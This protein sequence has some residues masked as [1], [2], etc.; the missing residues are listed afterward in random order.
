MS[1]HV[2]FYSSHPIVDGF[3]VRV[4]PSKDNYA[5]QDDVREVVSQA[6]TAFGVFHDEWDQVYLNETTKA[7]RT[8]YGQLTCTIHDEEFQ[9][10]IVTRVIRDCDCYQLE[11]EWCNSAEYT[12]T[13]SSKQGLV[14][15][16]HA[17]LKEQSR[18]RSIYFVMPDFDP[19][20]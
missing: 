4:D 18:K 8:R 20:F 3:G 15:D 10:T 9:Y 5:F 1:V 19:W 11:C 2:H 12:T 16:L 7:Y 14:S 6:C 13:Y 17:I